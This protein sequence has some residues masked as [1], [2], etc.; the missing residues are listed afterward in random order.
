MYVYYNSQR[1]SRITGRVRLRKMR[2]KFNAISDSDYSGSKS[3][4][5]VLVASLV[6]VSRSLS[7]VKIWSHTDSSVL[8]HLEETW[9]QSL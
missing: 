6:G 9:L 4:H 7:L 1:P 5:E 3:S 8:V 2:K